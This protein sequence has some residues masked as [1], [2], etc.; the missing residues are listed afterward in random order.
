LQTAV[1]GRDAAMVAED[2]GITVSNVYTSKCR[3]VAKIRDKI[4]ELED[5]DEIP[6]FP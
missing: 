1:D 4:A 3:V 6:D 5:S 2:L